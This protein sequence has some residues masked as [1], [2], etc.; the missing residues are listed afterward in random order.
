MI[1]FVYFHLFPSSSAHPDTV[2]IVALFCRP[3]SHQTESYSCCVCVMMKLLCSLSRKFGSQI[4]KF[5]KK[6]NI[7]LYT[8]SFQIHCVIRNIIRMK[9][10][11]YKLNI[12]HMWSNCPTFISVHVDSSFFVFFTWLYLMYIL[13]KFCFQMINAVFIL[14]WSK[15]HGTTLMMRMYCN[16]I[17]KWIENAKY[18]GQSPV[19]Y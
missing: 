18:F 17:W 12:W 4:T 16:T 11:N 19:L 8:S 9:S 5:V 7:Y 1:P 2:Q 13:Y 14:F 15:Q 10:L 6:K 3:A